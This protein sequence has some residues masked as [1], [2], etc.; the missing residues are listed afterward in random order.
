MITSQ[1]RDDDG[2]ESTAEDD[3]L[4]DVARINADNHLNAPAWADG[5]VRC[6]VVLRCI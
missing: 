6:G 4:D 5:V 1:G 2:Q 3:A